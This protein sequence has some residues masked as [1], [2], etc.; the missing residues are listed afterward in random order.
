M[1]KE[2]AVGTKSGALPAYSFYT[3]SLVLGFPGMAVSFVNLYALDL[4]GAAFLTVPLSAH[5]PSNFSLA[6]E[7]QQ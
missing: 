2:R 4:V 3:S 5:R 6:Q 1:N 7:G